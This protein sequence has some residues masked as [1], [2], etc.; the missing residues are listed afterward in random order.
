MTEHD[1]MREALFRG[2]WRVAL[3]P[4]SGDQA[5][6]RVEM[7][8]AEAPLPICTTGVLVGLPR[9]DN[10]ARALA[11]AIAQVPA[12]LRDRQRLEALLRE[13]AG[14]NDAEEMLLALRAVENDWRISRGLGLA[15]EIHAL[16]WERVKLALRKAGEA[17]ED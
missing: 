14:R 15:P 16:T 2:P 7:G 1:Q 10:I 3:K 11:E 5:E 12:L 8:P 4:L 6:V 13:G 9:L 17:C